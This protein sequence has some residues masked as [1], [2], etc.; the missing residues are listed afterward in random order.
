METKFKKGDFV[1][2]VSSVRRVNGDIISDVIVTI[3]GTVI[4]IIDN[5]YFEEFEVFDNKKDF[6]VKSSITEMF[7]GD[8]VYYNA[9]ND[10]FNKCTEKSL[11]LFELAK[12]NLKKVSHNTYEYI[13][14]NLNGTAMMYNDDGDIATTGVK[15]DKLLI[16][17]EYDDDG[18]VYAD[19]FLFVNDEPI[20][21]F[22]N[23]SDKTYCDIDRILKTKILNLM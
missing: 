6:V 1:Y 23:F 13:I 3:N 20:P 11:A 10:I 15:Y 2:A 22:D 16:S 21:V 7:T 4:Y 14:D 9:I 8:Q 17:I 18:E 5:A 12:E 19:W